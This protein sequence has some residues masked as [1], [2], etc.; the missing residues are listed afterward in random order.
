[1]NANG[2]Y[3]N[4]HR[5]KHDG[6][7]RSRRQR[8][9]QR[10]YHVSEQHKLVGEIRLRPSQRHEATVC[11]AELLPNPWPP[12]W[13]VN[14]HALTRLPCWQQE[15]IGN[16]TRLYLQAAVNSLFI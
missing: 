9:V 1:M 12:Q 2:F 11:R 6:H 5:P 10:D 4:S 16:K 13:L 7:T 15:F 8:L 14:R 3:S